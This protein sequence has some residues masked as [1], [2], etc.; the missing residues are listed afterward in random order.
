MMT[1]EPL[2][3]EKI[4]SWM[5]VTAEMLADVQHLRDVIEYATTEHPPLTARELITGWRWWT[6]SG[7]YFVRNPEPRLMAVSW[8]A[9][10]HRTRQRLDDLRHPMRY[11]TRRLS[12]FDRITGWAEEPDA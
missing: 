8:R 9:A 12:W 7:D 3:I 10:L 1:G 4:A 11:R 6:P 5:P 2:H